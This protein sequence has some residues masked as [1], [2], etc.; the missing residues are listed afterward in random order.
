MA[1]FVQRMIGAARLDVAT[2]EEVERDPRAVLIDVRTDAEWR[3]VGLPDLSGVGKEIA[4]ISWQTYPDMARNGGFVDQVRGAGVAEDQPV[5]LICRSGQRSR[6]A[7]IALT[8]AGFQSAH[9]VSEGFEGGHDEAGHRGRIA[10]WKA[11]GLPW[12]QG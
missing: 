7:A 2:Y 6:D 8:A 12:R 4:L 9:N 1:T 3:Y 10:G 11:R 5:Y